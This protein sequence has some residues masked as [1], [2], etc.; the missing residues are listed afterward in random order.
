MEKADKILE[1]LERQT[2][3][4]SEKKLLEDFANSDDEIKEF[5]KIYRNLEATLSASGHIHPDLLS[6]YILFEMGDDSES[7]LISII[8]NKIKNHLAECSVCRDEYN[9]LVS[10]YKN[11]D[12]LVGKSVQRDS[13]VKAQITP[14]IFVS[15]IR[16]FIYAFAVLLVIFI[17]YQGIYMMTT[18]Q[19]P[20]Y[21][22]GIFSEDH[23]EFYTTRGRTSESFQQGLNAIENENFTEAIQF[24]NKDIEEHQNE[25]SIFYTYYIK[26]ITYL[27]MSESDFIGLFKSYDEENVK[28]AISNLNQ[29]I[30]KNISGDYENLKLD[31]YYYIGRAY[32]L[33]DEKEPA[34]DNLKKVI[35]GRGK[36]SKESA[37]LISQLENN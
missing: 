11:I 6:S 25:R 8:K 12:Q 33:N 36:F 21:K 19:V 16:S 24:L 37:D 9:L 22:T 26:G 15:R 31:A 14:G 29:S 1:L 32:L 27:K 7:K 18:S 4:E 13:N 20:G 10:E 28:L 17:G 35:A 3:T 5:I 34:I 23:N 2:L 30:E